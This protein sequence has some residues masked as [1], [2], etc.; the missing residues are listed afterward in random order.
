MWPSTVSTRP[1]SH[2]GIGHGSGARWAARSYRPLLASSIDRTLPPRRRPS[3]SARIGP[4]SPTSP[5]QPSRRRRSRRGGGSG[6]RWRLRAA[7]TVAGSAFGIVESLGSSG[8]SLPRPARFGS[9]ERAEGV[10]DH[11][12]FSVETA[13]FFP[14]VRIPPSPLARLPPTSARSRRPSGR[15]RVCVSPRWGNRSSGVVALASRACTRGLQ[16]SSR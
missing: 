16:S 11:A 9:E 8:E 6:S 7:R 2:G 13:S 1:G 10:D 12:C 14:R 15:R 3:S 4:N 5:H